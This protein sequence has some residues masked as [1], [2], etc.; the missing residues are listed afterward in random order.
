MVQENVT[1]LSAE[2]L[3]AYLMHNRPIDRRLVDTWRLIRRTKTSLRRA[4][5]RRY[6]KLQGDFLIGASVLHIHL[7]FVYDTYTPVLHCCNN[8]SSQLVRGLEKNY[9]YRLP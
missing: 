3:N 4:F 8:S 9:Y 7:Y 1:E 2:N 6:G 5:K